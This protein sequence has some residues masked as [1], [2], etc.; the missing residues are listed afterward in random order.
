MVNNA[1]RVLRCEVLPD[2][3]FQ[4]SRLMFLLR[5]KAAARSLE[6]VLNDCEFGLRGLQAASRGLTFIMQ[7]LDRFRGGYAGELSIDAIEVAS[8]LLQL[9]CKYA[10]T[11]LGL[12]QRVLELSE[13]RASVAVQ[14]QI[15]FLLD[16]LRTA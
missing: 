13:K 2:A 15:A 16:A 7:T 8:V 10:R 11:T 9:L 1:Q 14:R 12:F 5:R 6:L 3:L 4:L